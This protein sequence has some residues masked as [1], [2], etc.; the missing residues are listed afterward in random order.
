MINKHQK[1][2][3]TVRIIILAIVPVLVFLAYNKNKVLARDVNISEMR[4]IICEQEEAGENI[5][6]IPIGRATDQ[7]EYLGGEIANEI[8]VLIENA[9]QLNEKAGAMPL[10]TERLNISNCEPECSVSW[11]VP[12][13]CTPGYTCDY[14]NRTHTGE[15]IMLN[16]WSR[17]DC[18]NLTNNLWIDSSAH[19]GIFQYTQQ[20][21]TPSG[22]TPGY[23]CDYKNYTHSGAIIEDGGY[24]QQDCQNLPQNLS[25]DRDADY[26]IFEYVHIAT[27]AGGWCNIKVTGGGGVSGWCNNKAIPSY[28]PNPCQPNNQ[29]PSNDIASA[30][31]EINSSSQIIKQ[32]QE[33]IADLTAQMAQAFI[34]LEKSRDRL[35]DCVIRPFEQE[36][37]ER[38]EITG[39]FLLS[40]QSIMDAGLIVNSYLGSNLQELQEGCYNDEYCQVLDIENKPLPFPP[41]PCADDFYCCY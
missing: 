25:I 9:N 6:E 7:T 23:T 14:Q 13:G 34:K 39:V 27:G 38:G 33:K 40:C 8:G 29:W 35:A 36:A 4:T 30:Q 32:S 12:Q 2:S 28:A 41:A 22:C 24:S 37:L 1:I 21:T 19:Y 10:L 17:Q 3:T 15:E 5:L 26:G 18:Q 20:S 11:D 16:N 31:D